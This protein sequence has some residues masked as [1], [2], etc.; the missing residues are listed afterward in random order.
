MAT[1][2]I[3]SRLAMLGLLPGGT[4]DEVGQGLGQLCFAKADAN[5]SCIGR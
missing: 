5:M 1:M 4:N 2:T 3:P